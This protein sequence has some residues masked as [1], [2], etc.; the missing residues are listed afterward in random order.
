MDDQTIVCDPRL[1]SAILAAVDERT[2]ATTRGGKRNVGANP[3]HILRHGGRRQESR[4]G[5][6][7]E[8]RSSQG[9]SEH[10]SGRPP[11]LGRS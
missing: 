10:A 3:R 9:H 5:V 1:V 7:Y 4:R 11:R 8:W 2:E 6:E